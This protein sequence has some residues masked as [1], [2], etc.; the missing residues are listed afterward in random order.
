METTRQFDI[1]Y[2]DGQQ[3]DA[4]CYCGSEDPDM[5]LKWLA[6]EDN[7]PGVE[8][9][10]KLDGEF[11]FLED[12]LESTPPV[13]V[14]IDSVDVSGIPPSVRAE[15]L[16]GS[17]SPAKPD[18]PASKRIRQRAAVTMYIYPRAK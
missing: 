17:W 9:S 15:M 5:I 7:T 8:I 14:K 18:S 2:R 6:T 1:T 4:F 12:Y 3:R 16:R 11:I 13:L 10:C